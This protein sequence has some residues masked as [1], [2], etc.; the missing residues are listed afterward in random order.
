MIDIATNKSYKTL[1]KRS[2]LSRYR[3]VN[4]NDPND[5]LNQCSQAL[6]YKD[7]C[8]M[9]YEEDDY[10]NKLQNPIDKSNINL[11]STLYFD[12]G[13]SFP[14]L[15]LDG[16]DFKRCIKIDRADYI[17]I[18]RIT[19]TFVK[20]PANYKYQIEQNNKVYLL[21][22]DLKDSYPC[23]ADIL[24]PFES[25]SGYYYTNTKKEAETIYNILAN[26]NKPII[27]E[28]ELDSII[29]KDLEKLDK[30]SIESI[31][32]MLRSKDASSVELGCKVLSSFDVNECNLTTSIL[33]FLTQDSWITNKGAKSVLFKNML[34]SINYPDYGYRIVDYVFKEHSAVSEK[35]RTLAK[36]LI[37][38]WIIQTI[39]QVVQFNIEKCPFK[40]NI[41]VEVE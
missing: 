39:E 18:P 9:G 38:P 27:F 17:V 11:K 2:E 36:N 19:T 8:I 22:E 5:V 7:Y 21:T 40:I 31:Y 32:D 23:L 14:R 1:Y 24:E 28:K 13:S 15:K 6:D 34:N 41:E 12:K 20:F 35:D 10:K 16:T 26:Y 33:L 30:D 37:K 29:S 25:T 4:F 3:Q